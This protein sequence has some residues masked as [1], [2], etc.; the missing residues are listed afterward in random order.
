MALLPVVVCPTSDLI[1]GDDPCPLNIPATLTS[2]EQEVLGLMLDGR[3]NLE[4]AV[5]LLV[6]MNTVE[7]HVRN[8]LRKHGCRD[9]VQLLARYL[10]ESILSR[11][12]LRS[13]DHG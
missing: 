10:N 2:R 12:V 9:R 8:V 11:D 13:I 1:T 6:A 3:S 5:L 7:R 4:I